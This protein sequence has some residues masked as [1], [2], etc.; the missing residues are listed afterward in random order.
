[1]EDD[2]SGGEKKDEAAPKKPKVEINIGNEHIKKLEVCLLRT[3]IS[4]MYS[5][6]HAKLDNL[7]IG[8]FQCMWHRVH[9]QCLVS[10]LTST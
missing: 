9:F 3:I 6:E 7:D 1:M 8:C 2:D 4:C 10:S 5:Q